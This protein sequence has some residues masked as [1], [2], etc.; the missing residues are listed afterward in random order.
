MSWLQKK[1]DPAAKTLE[2]VDD[3][4]VIGFFKD[5]ASADAKNFNQETTQ[6]NILIVVF[7]LSSC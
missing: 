3:V 7:H 1:T 4:A 6:T 5:L 2:I